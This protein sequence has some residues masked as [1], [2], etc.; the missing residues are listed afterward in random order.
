MGSVNLHPLLIRQQVEE[1]LEYLRP[2]FWMHG[3]N[4]E[5]IRIEEDTLYVRLFGACSGC[6]S[7]GNTLKLLVEAELAREVPQIKHVVEEE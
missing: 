2:Q 4:I 3:G 5:L 6:P 1:V 7:S